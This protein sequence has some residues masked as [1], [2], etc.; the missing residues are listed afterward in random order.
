MNIVVLADC[1]QMTL[2]KLILSIFFG[3]VVINA[4][5]GIVSLFA[6]EFGEFKSDILLTSLSISTASDLS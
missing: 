6:T 5:M 2:R 3:S 1:A 4:V